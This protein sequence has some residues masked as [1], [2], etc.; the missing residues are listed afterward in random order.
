[1]TNDNSDETHGRRNVLAGIAGLGVLGAGFGA[2]QVSGQAVPDGELGTP[3]NPYLRAHI[4]RQRYLGRTSDPSSP[5]DG[6]TW[7]RE[8]Q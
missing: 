7:Y 1:M 6:T 3:G 2:G 8:D 4:D 5:S